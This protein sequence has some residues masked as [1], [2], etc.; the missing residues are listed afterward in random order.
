MSRVQSA[1][2]VMFELDTE[3]LVSDHFNAQPLECCACVVHLTLRTISM[4]F[5]CSR[6]A[7]RTSAIPQ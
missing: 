7:T 2:P 4:G 6:T 1:S 3:C 5:T